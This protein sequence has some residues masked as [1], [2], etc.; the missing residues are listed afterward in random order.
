MLN[1]LNDH[2]SSLIIKALWEKIEESFGK[3]DVGKCKLYIQKCVQCCWF[4]CVQDPALHLTV[5][6]IG[7]K[8][9][10]YNMKSF[11]KNGQYVD[12]SVWPAL[13]LHKDGPLLSKGIVQGTNQATV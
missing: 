7:T 13:Y 5:W 10:G 8:M 9:D 12:F 3:G 11:T 2:F 4:M 1:F 6:T